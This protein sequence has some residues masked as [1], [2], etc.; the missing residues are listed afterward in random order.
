ME[1]FLMR[2]PSQ[3]SSV[4]RQW[5]LKLY[6]QT[7]YANRHHGTGFTDQPDKSVADEGLLRPTAES[8]RSPS[9]YAYS[10]TEC[11]PQPLVT[12]AMQA[13][14]MLNIPCQKK[15]ITPQLRTRSA[16]STYV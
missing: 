6:V 9:T 15:A 11:T 14:I 10:S 1:N 3:L 13:P 16:P 8:G 4:R 5:M 7:H 2:M 12:R